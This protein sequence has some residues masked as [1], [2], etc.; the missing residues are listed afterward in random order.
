MQSTVW[1]T[2][3]VA[4]A[5]KHQDLKIQFCEKPGAAILYHPNRIVLNLEDRGDDCT[6]VYQACSLFRP[7]D[8]RIS[9]HVQDQRHQLVGAVLK[10]HEQQHI[11]HC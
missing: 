3:S 2:T 9:Q 8:S 1:S 11:C 6:R 5:F 10:A 4:T 7:L